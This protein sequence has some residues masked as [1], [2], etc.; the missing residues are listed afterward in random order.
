MQQMLWS[1][2]PIE[3]FTAYMYLAKQGEK[4]HSQGNKGLKAKF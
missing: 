4:V 2:N 1:F 3:S